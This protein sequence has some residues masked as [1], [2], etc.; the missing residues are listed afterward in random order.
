MNFLGAIMMIVVL[1]AAAMAGIY[2]LY[3]FMVN[4]QPGRN[5]INKDIQEFR[6]EL[7][8]LLPELVPLDSEEMELL[9]LNQINVSR[10]KGFTKTVKGTFTSIFHEPLVTY[11]YKRYMGSDENALI[12]ARTKD[13]QLN[14]RIKKGEI[15]IELDNRPLG[16]LKQNSLLYGGRQNKLLAKVNRDSHENLLP[17]TVGDQEVGM[18]VRPEKARATNPRAFELLKPMGKEEE[19]VLLSLSVLEAV[20]HSVRQQLKK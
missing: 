18:M 17:I 2:L 9:S 6:E 7:D 12:V 8:L 16:V 3:Q 14:Y 10:S 15:Q 20:Q 11:A 1:I 13:H 4:W 19:L 5:K